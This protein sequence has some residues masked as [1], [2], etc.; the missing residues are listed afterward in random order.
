MHYNEK[1]MH[2]VSKG[3]LV[4]VPNFIQKSPQKLTG[5]GNNSIQQVLT[6]SGESIYVPTINPVI[7]RTLPTCGQS[8]HP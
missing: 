4:I 8:H 6:K 5:G 7:A 3:L 2:H 1:R